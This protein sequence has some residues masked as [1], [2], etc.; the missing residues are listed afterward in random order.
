MLLR[1]SIVLK[2]TCIDLL[3]QSHVFAYF[4]DA[5]LLL[6]TVFVLYQRGLGMLGSFL[7]HGC[8]IQAG[9]RLR[10]RPCTFFSLRYFVIALS[11]FCLEKVA[12]ILGDDGT[13]LPVT[14]TFHIR[15]PGY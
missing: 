5:L 9:A 15:I 2:H 7:L 10:G 13:A 12:R 8:G 6:G 1:V 11:L 14:I 4:G 3:R